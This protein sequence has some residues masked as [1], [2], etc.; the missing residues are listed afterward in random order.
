VEG[1]RG[2]ARVVRGHCFRLRNGSSVYNF[3]ELVDIF[4]LV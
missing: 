2:E 1:W 3:R 4:S